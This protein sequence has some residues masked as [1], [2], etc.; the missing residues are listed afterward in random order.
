MSSLYLWTGPHN[1]GQ[2][3]GVTQDT[4]RLPDAIY[5]NTDSFST[6][7]P[8]VSYEGDTY[9]G[10]HGLVTSAGYWNDMS[11]M[12]NGENWQNRVASI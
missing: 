3:A 6:T 10:A 9:Q 2:G 4:S 5:R 8:V 11:S 1:T 7:A 12:P